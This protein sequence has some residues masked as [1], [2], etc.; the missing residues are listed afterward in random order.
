MGEYLTF[1]RAKFVCGELRWTSEF[2][3]D[4]IGQ[5]DLAKDSYKEVFRQDDE[6]L[7]II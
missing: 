4:K 7:D 5:K 1:C 6:T 2:E 3:V